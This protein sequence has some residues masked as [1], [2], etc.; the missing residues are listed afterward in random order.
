[1]FIE[2]SK[3]YLETETSR[4]I[5][6]KNGLSFVVTLT[7]WHWEVL[8]FCEENFRFKTNGWY[9]DAAWDDAQREFQENGIPLGET[10]SRGIAHVALLAA[11]SELDELEGRA[12]TM[13]K[14]DWKADVMRRSINVTLD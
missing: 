13:R 1:V 12:N 10:F 7:N 5:E 4:L 6:T 8:R 14:A 11:E 9:I 3:E 2:G